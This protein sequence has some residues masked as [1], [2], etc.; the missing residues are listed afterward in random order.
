MHRNV[1]RLYGLSAEFVAHAPGLIITAISALL[2][3]RILAPGY[4]RVYG[5]SSRRGYALSIAAGPLSNVIIAVFGVL[6]SQSLSYPLEVV[7]SKVV[8]VNL[9][10]AFFSLLPIPP[11]DGHRLASLDIRIWSLLLILLVIVWLLW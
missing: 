3:I 2:P 9:W 8:E 7:V 10:L 11:L 6:F 4:V 5:S 1:A